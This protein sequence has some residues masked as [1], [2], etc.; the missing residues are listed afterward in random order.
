METLPSVKL[1]AKFSRHEFWNCRV[2]FLRHT[3]SDVEILECSVNL[4]KTV[5][6]LSAL[7]TLR[8]FAKF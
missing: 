8:K 3:I 6:K 4:S 1:F 5:E 7:K 2:K